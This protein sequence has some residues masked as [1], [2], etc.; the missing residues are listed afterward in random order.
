VKRENLSFFSFFLLFLVLSAGLRSQAAE[1]LPPP[2]RAYFNDAAAVVSAPVAAALNRELADFD[3]TTSHQIVVA[4]YPQSWSKSSPEDVAQQ[5][6]TAWHLGTKK[7]SNGVLV[8][9][10][11]KEHQVRI[12][13]GYGLE[14]AL[15]DALC[16]RI[17]EEKM[18]PAFQHGD[19]DSGLRAGLSEIMKATSQEHYLLPL[20][21]RSLSWK[22][23]LLSPFGFFLLLMLG[24]TILNRW[25]SKN[26][27]APETT[28]GGWWI[29]GGGWGSGGGSLG[30]G[31]DGGGFF[32][33]GGDS[34]GGGAGGGW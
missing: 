34:G 24:S 7:Y 23:I 27:I 32:G 16:K 22:N 20:K 5:L 21:K 13:T 28:G 11:K 19:Y 33:G 15:P 6:Y 10:F 29:G 3:R 17:I 31:E 14:G 1:Q 25:R 2:P 26:G 8:L 18:I 12:Q 9:V 30:G 4:I